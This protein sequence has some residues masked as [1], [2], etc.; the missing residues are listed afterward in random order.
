MAKVRLTPFGVV[1][2]FDDSETAQIVSSMNSGRG[3]AT[4]LLA[5]LASMG[6]TGSASVTTAIGNAL[7]WLGPSLLANSNSRQ[8]GI[9]L[10]VLWVGK[11]WCKPR[12]LPV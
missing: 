8:S 7:L 6:V 4:T 1:A 2:E 11:P 9:E 5:I 10:T 12:S 3:T